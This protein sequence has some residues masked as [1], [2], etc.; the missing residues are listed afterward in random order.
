MPVT[1]NMSHYNYYGQLAQALIATEGH[2]A[3]KYL[4][5]K[6]VI[7]ATRK[8]FGGKI[9]KRDRRVEIMF[10]D[11]IPNYHA[12]QFIKLCQR[13]KEPFPVKKIQL[14]LFP[15]RARS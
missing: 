4:T 6:H 10:T 12:R 5:P 15:K 14:T 8:V 13:A 2:T 1:S 11:G 9:N 3:T 7:R